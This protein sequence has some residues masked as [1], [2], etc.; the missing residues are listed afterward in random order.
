MHSSDGGDE[1]DDYPSL[2]RDT[3]LMSR[4]DILDDELLDFRCVPLTVSETLLEATLEG[5]GPEAIRLLETLQDRPLSTDDAL[6]VAAAWE[7]QSRWLTARAQAANVAFMGA[8]VDPSRDGERAE[9][10]RVFEL[11]MATDCNDTFLKHT[12]GRA[13][14]LTTTLTATAAKLET[15]ELSA[16]R[17]RLICEKLAG[18]DPQTARE[19]EARV[20][21]T[22]GQLKI[23]SLQAKLRK[24]VL[25]ARGDDAVAEHLAGI[26]NRRVTVDRDVAE[27]GLLGLHAYLPAETA[28]A[29]RDTLEAKA[30]EFGRADK[31]SQQQAKNDG[32]EPAPRRSKDQRLADALAWYVLGPDEQDPSRPARP[33]ILVQL[34]I[35][36]TTLLHLR[37]HPGDLGGYGPIPAD[38]ARILARDAD[39]QRFIHHPVTG[40]LLDAGPNLYR[41]PPALAQFTDVRDVT[42]RFPGSNRSAHLGD[43]DHREPFQQGT[44]GHTSAKNMP[45]LSRTGHIAKTH[46][47]WKCEGDANGIL[48]WTSPHGHT[49]PVPPHNYSDE[50]EP[51]PQPEAEPEPPF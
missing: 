45:R 30:Q 14:Q 40:Y 16:Y 10:S 38:I 32:R 33:K 31:A 3:L 17:V 29:V 41:P 4:D 2:S 24:Q 43:L 47:G 5:P 20:L 51:E 12:L 44:G 21:P 18:L 8:T 19:I 28:V 42:D 22:A 26:A 13:R 7:R 50:P 48:T 37:E 39:W 35:S 27:P 23:G 15:G 34:T 11:A 36:L 46:N 6:E 49:Y 25:A 9:Q 1:Y